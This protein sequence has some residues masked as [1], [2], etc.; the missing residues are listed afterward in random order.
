LDTCLL[1][2]TTVSCVG[3]VECSTLPSFCGL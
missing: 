1:S 3:K 2:C